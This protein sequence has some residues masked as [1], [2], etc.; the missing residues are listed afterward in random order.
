[1][2]KF[3]YS[4]FGI[5]GNPIDHSLSPHM[6]NAAFSKLKIKAVY[7]PFNIKRS[8]IKNTIGVFKKNSIRGFN[9]T[10]PFK[11]DCVKYLDA[12]DPLAEMIGAVNTVVLKG[13]KFVGYNTDYLGFI[14]SVKEEL[15]IDLSNAKVMILGAGGASRAVGFG[16]AKDG[17]SKLFIYDIEAGK[18]EKLANNI[19]HYF[20]CSKANAISIGNLAEC[21]KDV[22][23]LINCTPLGMNKKDPLPIDSRFL[24]KGLKVYD[25]VYNPLK[26]KLVKTASRKGI[27]ATGGLGMLLYQGAS[28]FE[29]WTK[30][31]APTALMRKV[32]LDLIGN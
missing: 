30:K 27:K 15:K 23:L 9:V 19:N 26:T 7:L 21:I 16:C 2:K 13:K 1:M 3:S 6:H 5:I 20:P 11:T 17:V 31:K 12:I 22:D 14:R 28:A 8:Q 32:L 10:I 29:L 18:A 24:H 4:V 25:I